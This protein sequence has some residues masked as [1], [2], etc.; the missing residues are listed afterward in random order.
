MRK[1]KQGDNKFAFTFQV[2]IVSILLGPICLFTYLAIFYNEEFPK[3]LAVYFP[4]VLISLFFFLPVLLI[5]TI[6]YIIF[7]PKIKNA[8]LL[9]SI[10]YLITAAALIFTFFNLGGSMVYDFIISYLFSTT[11]AF[12]LIGIKKTDSIR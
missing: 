12:I 11:V 1:N 4:V 5:T 10:L 9:K 8:T 7:G 2:W 3:F 6:S